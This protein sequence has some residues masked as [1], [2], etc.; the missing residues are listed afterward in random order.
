[1][2]VLFADSLGSSTVTELEARGHEC[3]VEPTL[4]AGDLAGRIPGFDVLV[5]R[6]TK[7]GAEVFESGDKL[8]LVIR[9]GAGT[10][11]IDTA[12][13]AARGVLVANLPGRNAIAVAELT[14]GL[15]LAVDRHIVDATVDLRAGRWDKKRYSAARGLF[16]STMGILGLGSIGLEVAQRARAFGMH[17]LVL[18]KPDRSA[19]TLARLDEMRVGTVDSLEELLPACDVVSLHL[20]SNADTAGLVDRKFLAQMKPGAV[21]LNTSRGELVD[22]DALLEALEE[23]DLRAGLDVYAD[24]PGSGQAEWTSR[25]AQHPRVVGTH[26]IGASTQQAQDAIADGVVEI[27]DA[28]VRGEPPHCV[29]L[30]PSRIG[31][32]TLT[33]RHLDRVGVLARV[34]DLLSRHGLNVEQMQNRV[35]RGGEAAVATMDVAGATTDD[36]LAELAALPDVLGVSSTTIDDA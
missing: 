31:T 15:L 36:L 5:V 7:V 4:Q 18:A 34:L 6:S 3:V 32:A 25:L 2:R 19:R 16:G 17:V 1:M 11:T 30:T 14:M 28:F 20:P 12:T 9:A 33:V 35:F 8:A 22:E 10:N 26:H 23:R 13:A 27:V 29:N 24:E 21:L